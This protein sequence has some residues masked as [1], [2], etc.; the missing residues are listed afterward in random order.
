MFAFELTA[1]SPLYIFYAVDLLRL[2]RANGIIMLSRLYGL[3]VYDSFNTNRA[4]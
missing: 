4:I 1:M 2:S 3:I